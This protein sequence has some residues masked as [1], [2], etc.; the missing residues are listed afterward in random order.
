[1]LTGRPVWVQVL[2]ALVALWII[3]GAALHFVH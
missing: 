2:V 3:L 1:V